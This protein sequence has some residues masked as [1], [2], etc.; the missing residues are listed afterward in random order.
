MKIISCDFG[1]EKIFRVK[2][3]PKNYHPFIKYF[4]DNSQIVLEIGAG[5]LTNILKY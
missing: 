2:G 5:E 1:L 4:R 3:Y